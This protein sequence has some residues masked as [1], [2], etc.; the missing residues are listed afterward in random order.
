MW[1]EF[2]SKTKPKKFTKMQTIYK[3]GQ[4]F[5]IVFSQFCVG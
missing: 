3:N 2:K 5:G 4:R 1:R